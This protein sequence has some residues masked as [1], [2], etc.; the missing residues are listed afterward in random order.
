MQ[1]LT[2]PKTKIQKFP[3]YKRISKFAKGKTKI[4]QFPKES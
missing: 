4:L 3:E 1:K 2:I